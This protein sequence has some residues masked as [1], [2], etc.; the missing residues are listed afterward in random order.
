MIIKLGGKGCLMKNRERMLRL[1]ALRI[2]PVDATGAGDHFAAGFVS[3]IL[4]G[5]S[6]E[7]ALRFANA[8][9][10][11]CTTA[12]GAGTALKDREQVLG[13]LA[14]DRRTE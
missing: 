12:V 5:A 6:P 4:R 7:E 1:P 13:F 2:D 14:A 9:G 11:V 3:E 8:C 10:A